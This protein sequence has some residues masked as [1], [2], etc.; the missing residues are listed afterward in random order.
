MRVDIVYPDFVAFLPRGD[1]G[2]MFTQ[3]R[4]FVAHKA[5][6][7]RW[8]SSLIHGGASGVSVKVW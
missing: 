2:V 7:A 1:V 8:P 5:A 6:S 4:T 3:N